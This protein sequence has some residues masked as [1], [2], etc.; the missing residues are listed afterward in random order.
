MFDFD[1][2]SNC[3]PQPTHKLN[4][5]LIPTRDQDLRHMR[6]HVHCQDL[7]GVVGYHTLTN[8]F[9]LEDQNGKAEIIDSNVVVEKNTQVLLGRDNSINHFGKHHLDILAYTFQ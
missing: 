8:K 5:A 7:H 3:V 6:H 4:N 1:K 9:C 2:T